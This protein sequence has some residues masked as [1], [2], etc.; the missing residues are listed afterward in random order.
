MPLCF[1]EKRIGVVFFKLRR[2]SVE[3]TL[4]PEGVGQ[5]P[6]TWD[7]RKTATCTKAREEDVSACN[8]CGASAVR[9]AGVFVVT[10]IEKL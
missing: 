3:E 5:N 2:S 4:G 8:V 7:P 9:R 1:G 10:N 6:D